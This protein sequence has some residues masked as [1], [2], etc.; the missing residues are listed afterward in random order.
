MVP[1]E[2][3]TPSIGN[4]HSSSVPEGF[5]YPSTASGPCIGDPEKFTSERN[6]LDTFLAQCAIVFMAKSKMYG[7]VTITRLHLPYLTSVA[8]PALGKHIFA[9]SPVSP[10]DRKRPYILYELP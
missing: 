1:P 7:N 10:P 9:R 2:R 6:E 3:E 5:D 4:V 8:G